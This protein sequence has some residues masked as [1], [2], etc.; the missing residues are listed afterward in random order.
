MY[1]FVDQPIIGLSRG[2]QL[3]L[4]AM[5]GWTH[6]LN[7]GHCPPAALAPTFER[8]GVIDALPPFHKMM[9]LLNHYAAHEFAFGCLTE[10]IIGEDE[11]I[12]LGLWRHVAHR[13]F[14]N[15]EATLEMISSEGAA[16]SIVQAMSVA[17]NVFSAKNARPIGMTY[18]A[19]NQA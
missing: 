12:L 8:L 15:A 17:S 6:Q 5:R 2:S 4:W 19:T 11:A 1:Q 14:A 10:L 13:Q 9:A 7:N 18:M 16:K 3:V